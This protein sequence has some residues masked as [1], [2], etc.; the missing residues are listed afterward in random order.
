M[1]LIPVQILLLS[2]SSPLLLKENPHTPQLDF[3]LDCLVLSFTE[4]YFI[5]E[6]FQEAHTLLA[7]ILSR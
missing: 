3:K 5:D 6:T 4:L 2:D 1:S 7:T